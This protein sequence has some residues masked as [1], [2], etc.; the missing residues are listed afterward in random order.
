[1]RIA[2]I[3]PL[4][5][6]VPPKL[7]G[8]TERVIWWLTEALVDLGH[9]VT[10]YASGDSKTSARLIPGAETGLRLQGINDHTASLLAMLER[11]RQ[12]A[13]RYD[14]LHFHIDF[15][16]FPT[17]RHL[18]D[19]SLT[20]LHGRQDL[21]DFLPA[22]RTFREMQLVSISDDQRRPIPDARFAGTVHHGL[23]ENLIPFD[24][25]G[26]DYLAF[27]GRISPEKRPDRA[28]EIARRAGMKLK[29]AAKVD[30]ADRA[31]FA[32][33]I[34]PLLD[35]PLIEFIGEIGD[36]EKPAFLGGARALLFPIDWPEPFG[37]VM[38]EAMAAGTPVI[39]WPN[40]STRE[41][42][43]HGRS[44]FLVDSIEEAVAAVE[45]AG[46]VP[47]EGV[48]AAFEER[49]TARRMAMDYVD[50]YERLLG[51]ET[52]SLFGKTMTIAG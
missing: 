42:I 27:I 37:L 14:V 18:A 6:A 20:T 22:F 17:F 52:T 51:T 28:I 36:A 34:E 4:A 41:V 21:P 9:D 38:I 33:R 31:Y 46:R 32:D 39:A 12:D 30:H 16:H 10:L 44:G 48:R 11:V 49:F 35:D 8:G 7:Y 3:A 47:R 26:G 29:I 50:L 25:R 19:K 40:G 43:E 1:M 23:P 13:G 15:L 45:A 24:A 2:Q 5:E